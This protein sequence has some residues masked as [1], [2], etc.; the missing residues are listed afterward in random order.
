V[1]AAAAAAEVV[2]GDRDVAEETVAAVVVVQAMAE[3]VD[4]KHTGKC[5]DVAFLH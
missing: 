5:H 3:V 2:V 1:G 4:I